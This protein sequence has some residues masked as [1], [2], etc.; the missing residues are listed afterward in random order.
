[1]GLAYYGLQSVWGKEYPER[2]TGVDVTK[3]LFKVAADTQI[4]VYCL[5]AAPGVA[6]Q[7]VSNLQAMFGPIKYCGGFMMV[8]LMKLRNTV[9]LKILKIRVLNLYLLH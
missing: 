7:A 5:G 8:S 3:E 2:V 6:E 1:M 9:L 4:P